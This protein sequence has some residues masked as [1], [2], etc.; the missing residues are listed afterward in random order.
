MR[1]GDRSMLV[2]FVLLLAVGTSLWLAQTFVASPE[3]L[4]ADVIQNRKVIKSF[5]LDAKAAPEEL[6]IKYNGGYNTIYVEG[7][8]I[9]IIDADCPDRDCVR[10]GWL[11]HAGESTICLPHRLEIR[12]S[13]RSDVDGVSY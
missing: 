4:R 13:G 9:A 12:I 5:V 11:K 1:R 7:G 10:R 6:T 3:M 2:I 8:R